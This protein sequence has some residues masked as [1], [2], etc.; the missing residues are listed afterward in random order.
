MTS[1]RKNIDLIKT[2][3]SDLEILFEFQLDEEANYL[4]AF[5]PKDPSD[6]TAYIEKFTKHINDPTINMWTII[7]DDMIAGSI[8][9]FVM[10]GNAEITFWIDKEYWGQGIA[11]NALKNF[12]KLEETRPI[13]GRAAYD[14]F[15]S[16]KV[17]EKCGFKKT[18]TDKGF[19]NARGKVIEEFIYKLD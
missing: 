1:E 13:R 6:K 14:N 2:T 11:T 19:A 4:A 15:A 16:Q 17:M 8:A 7:V 9:K 3:E 5:T 10:E 12:L 18:G